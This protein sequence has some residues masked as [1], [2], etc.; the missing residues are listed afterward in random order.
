[1]GRDEDAG[2]FPNRT[3]E[4]LGIGLEVNQQSN[5]AKAR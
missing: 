4:F 1:M 2:N 5:N 3:S